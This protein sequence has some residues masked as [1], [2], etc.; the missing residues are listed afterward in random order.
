MLPLMRAYF[1][2]SG[3]IRGAH[4][5]LSGEN[6]LARSQDIVSY[7]WKWHQKINIFI[8]NQ[9][10]ITKLP[11]IAYKFS[12]SHV[13]THISMFITSHFSWPDEMSKLLKSGIIFFLIAIGFVF[14]AEYKHRC[15]S[16]FKSRSPTIEP[17]LTVWNS[18]D[19]SGY[20][21]AVA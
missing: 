8:V 15:G 10:V 16:D 13:K 4:W 11:I 17:L 6:S 18:V 21:R 9:P 2:T 5:K 3:M 20:I 12:C 14:R 19:A 7:K 1:K